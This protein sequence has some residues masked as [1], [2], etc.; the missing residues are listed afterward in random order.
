MVLAAVSIRISKS[1]KA[2]LICVCFSEETIIVNRVIRED[3]SK[4]TMHNRQPVTPKL[5]WQSLKD[6]DLWPIYVTGLTFQTPMTTPTQYLTL[7]LK[8]LG[9]DTF[10]T[11]LLTIPSTFFH[12]VLMMVLTYSSEILG[13]LSLSA[14]TGQIWALP[15]LIY[16]Y[17]VDINTV[18]KWIAWTIMTLLLSYPSGKSLFRTQ[19]LY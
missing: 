4:G 13:E 1:I 2:G 6:Y 19:Q 12:M 14:M 16:I 9:F 11:N 8:G 17:V 5:L 18:N 10:Q 7:S 3:P 15:F